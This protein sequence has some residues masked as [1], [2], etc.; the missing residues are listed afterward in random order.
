[1]IVDRFW[2]LNR[3]RGCWLREGRWNTRSRN[4]TVQ[5]RQ[6]RSSLLGPLEAGGGEAWGGPRCWSPDREMAFL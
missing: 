6:L 3:E 4:R 5:S 2:V 1:M